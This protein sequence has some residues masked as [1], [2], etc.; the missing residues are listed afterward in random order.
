MSIPARTHAFQTLTSTECSYQSHWSA[1]LS[2]GH[3]ALRCA[4]VFQIFS[5]TLKRIQPTTF[6]GPCLPTGRL[7]RRAT[8]LN[9]ITVK[10][11]TRTVFSRPKAVQ[12]Q[13]LLSENRYLAQNFRHCWFRCLCRSS[14]IL[15]ADGKPKDLTG[16]AFVGMG[17][18][19]LWPRQS[20]SQ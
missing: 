5:Q 17:P 3:S 11:L 18:L 8:A 7:C 12:Y 16:S 6:L 15:F 14:L 13:S 1:C 20:A 10:C 19:A 4:S 2:C 9:Q